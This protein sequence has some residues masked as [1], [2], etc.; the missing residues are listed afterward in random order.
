M[1]ATPITFPNRNKARHKTV[2]YEIMEK[3]GNTIKNESTYL[4]VFP[5]Q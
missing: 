4:D 3:T 1:P 2:N 5:L